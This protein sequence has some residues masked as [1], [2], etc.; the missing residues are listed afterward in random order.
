MK[1]RGI[2]G[3]MAIQEIHYTSEIGNYKIKV[4]LS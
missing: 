2:L 3:I 1:Q 4:R